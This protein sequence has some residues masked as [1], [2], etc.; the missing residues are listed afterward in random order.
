MKCRVTS[1]CLSSHGKNTHTKPTNTTKKQKKKSQTLNTIT[2]TEQNNITQNRT[3]R[4]TLKTR[5]TAQTS[6]LKNKNFTCHT[7]HNTKIDKN[8]QTPT[9]SDSPEQEFSLVIFLSNLV[10]FHAFDLLC[11]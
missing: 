11:Q 7:K 6:T 4:Q 5:K 3:S 10:E 1:L 9:N 8:E 2:N